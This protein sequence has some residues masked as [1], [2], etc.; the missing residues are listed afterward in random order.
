MTQS[1][2]PAFCTCIGGSWPTRPASSASL[3]MLLCWLLLLLLMWVLLV[4]LWR[5]HQ[6]ARMQHLQH[7]ILVKVP[8]AG[9]QVH[10][11][12]VGLHGV[13]YGSRPMNG[14]RGVT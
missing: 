8:M 7:T 9:V 4:L 11:V 2:V 1:T 5:Q 13:W 12:G 6:H 14:C 3:S 10:R